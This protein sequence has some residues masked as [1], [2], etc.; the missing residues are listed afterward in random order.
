MSGDKPGLSCPSAQPGMDGAR[1]LGVIER[2][3]GRKSVAY[4]N[5]SPVVSDEILQMAAPA[6]PTEVFRF[7]AKCEERNCTHFDG[8]DCALATRI[9]ENMMPVSEKLPPCWLRSTCRWHA[10]QGAQA[11][12]RCPQI[13]TTIEPDDSESRKIALP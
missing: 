10:Q 3:E 13:A 12:F 6:E 4:L 9:V 2:T 1:V 5:D 7:S 8:R 11:C